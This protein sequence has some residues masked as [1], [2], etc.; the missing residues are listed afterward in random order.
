MLSFFKKKQSNHVDRI[1]KRI[2]TT[3]IKFE[4]KLESIETFANNISEKADAYGKQIEKMRRVCHCLDILISD[5]DKNMQ[6]NFANEP[7]CTKIYGLS[8]MCTNEIVG[9]HELDL[10]NNY[11]ERTGNWNSFIS[12]SNFS[13]DRIVRKKL[14]IMTF[15][16]RG[17]INKK[18]IMLKTIVKPHT[19]NKKFDGLT[20]FSTILDDTEYEKE[21]KMGKLLY[22]KEDY[23]VYQL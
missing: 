10:I 17:I 9:K 20:S 1:K 8:E 14:E 5:K 13:I 12:F 4:S 16:Q 18:P 19:K 21:K 22:D 7:M 2:A 3:A 15:L 23:T 11:I 6:M